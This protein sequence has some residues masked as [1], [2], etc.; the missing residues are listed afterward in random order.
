MILATFWP[1]FSQTHLVTLPSREQNKMAATAARGAEQVFFLSFERVAAA[2]AARHATALAFIA[3][4]IIK[5]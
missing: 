4:C 5:N 2:A 1:I 3:G